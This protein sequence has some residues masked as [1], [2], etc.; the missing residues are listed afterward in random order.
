MEQDPHDQQS[1][2][3]SSVTE[4]KR[5]DWNDDEILTIILAHHIFK[6][7]KVPRNLPLL[8]QFLSLY[9]QLAEFTNDGMWK[10]V[11]LVM[12]KESGISPLPR[13]TELAA[14][15]KR[16]R[17]KFQHVQLVDSL[18]PLLTHDAST[19][20]SPLPFLLLIP[21]CVLI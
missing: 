19:D 18:D 2:K 21:S 4:L 3:L 13:S 17:N 20:N 6:E 12:L 10:F 16:C 14:V 7:K 5:K 1:D 15:V 11:S 9:K 8:L